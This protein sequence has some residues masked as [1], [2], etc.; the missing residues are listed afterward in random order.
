MAK[1]AWIIHMSKIRKENPKLAKSRPGS[2]DFK[3][4]IIIAKKTYKAK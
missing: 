1:N 2:P 4:L 3:K